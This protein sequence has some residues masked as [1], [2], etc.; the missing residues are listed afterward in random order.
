MAKKWQTIASMRRKTFFLPISSTLVSKATSCM[1]KPMANRGHFVIYTTDQKRFVVPLLYLQN[2]IFRALL[3]MSE[4]EFGLPIDG[5]IRLPCDEVFMKYIV[6][7]IQQGVAKDLET[8]LLLSIALNFGSLDS[9]QQGV[10]VNVNAELHIC[11]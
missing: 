4:K 2:N 3:K 7:I 1:N 11:G 6:K 10:T 5:P 8:A 9:S